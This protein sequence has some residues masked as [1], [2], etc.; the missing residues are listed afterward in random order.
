MEPADLGLLAYESE[1]TS[2][3]EGTAP[4]QVLPRQGIHGYPSPSVVNGVY[5]SMCRPSELASR[6]AKGAHLS[7]RVCKQDHARRCSWLPGHNL[8]NLS[9]SVIELR[10]YWRLG[11]D[12]EC[13]VRWGFVDDRGK[14]KRRW[15]SNHFVLQRCYVVYVSSSG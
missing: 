5:A 15:R 11:N 14:R 6:R 10:P 7:R 12:R 4:N 9:S 13:S 3:Y 1:R 8:E 2:S